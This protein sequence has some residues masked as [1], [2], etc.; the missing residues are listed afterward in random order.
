MYLFFDTETTGLPRNW[1]APLSDL[2]NWPRMI[3][4]AW[5]VFND[6]GEKIDSKDYIIKPENFTIPAE[7]SEIHGITT[8]RAMAEG[9]DLTYVLAVF[10]DY[11]N[12][13]DKLVAHNMSFDEKIVGAEFLRKNINSRL[14]K[15]ERICTMMSSK[16]FCAL[17]GRY[18]FKWPTLSELH[19]KLFGKDF[20]N[21]HDAYSDITATADCFWKLKEMNVV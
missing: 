8:E 20:E 2:D 5:F 15:K 19:I 12:R 3:Q 17:P 7:S 4:L 13:A 18:G 1:K 10:N 21:A 9:N 16:E 6:K 14:F 11:I